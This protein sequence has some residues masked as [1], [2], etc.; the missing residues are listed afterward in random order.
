MPT[1]NLE[2]NNMYPHR[3][4]TTLFSACADKSAGQTYIHSFSY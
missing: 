4:A 3:V 2:H 1:L